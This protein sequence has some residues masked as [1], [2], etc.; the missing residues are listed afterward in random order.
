LLGPDP[1]VE[2]MTRE[3]IDD[4]LILIRMIYHD[5][6]SVEDP[7]FVKDEILYKR[8][9]SDKARE[10]LSDSEL[11]RLINSGDIAELNSRVLK[12]GA[13]NLLWNNVPLQGDLAL[14]HADV[15][16]L[17]VFSQF[18]TLLYGEGSSAE[19]LQ[20]WADFLDSRSLN[21][22]WTTP[23]YFMFLTAP[24]S[25][26][27]IKPGAASW[28]LKQAGLDTALGAK[29]SG[30]IYGELRQIATQI[31]DLT[32]DL[33]VRDVID[34]QSMV[35]TAFQASQALRKRLTEIQAADSSIFD[36]R[37]KKAGFPEL[38]A[39][40]IRRVLSQIPLTNE[41][42]TS[43]IH[44]FK[45]GA[46]T[47]DNIRRNLEICGV[48][49]F[50]DEMMT[51]PGEGGYTA[52]GRFLINGL[53]ADQL[54]T[55]RQ[56]LLDIAN[57][58]SYKEVEQIVSAFEYKDVPLVK[59]GI[60]SPWIHYLQPGICPL[61]NGAVLE[62]YR[63]LGLPKQGTYTDALRIARVAARQIG[64]T[65]LGMLDALLYAESKIRLSAE[66]AISY[67]KIA[68]GEKA[69]QWDE[70]K[71]NGFIAVGWDEIGNVIGLDED[72]F[73]ARRKEVIAHDP[74]L[75]GQKS[76][77]KAHLRHL[78]EF[79]HLKPGD[80]VI[81]NQGIRLILGVGTVTG[82]PFFVEGVRHCHRIPVKWDDVSQKEINEPSWVRTMIRLTPQKFYQLTASAH[83]EQDYR[84]PPVSDQNAA[85]TLRAFELLDGICESPTKQYYLDHRDDF[86]QYI[87]QPF[88]ATFRAAVQ[89][90]PEQIKSFMET[91]DN[92]FSRFPKNDYG[93]GRAY[94]W[95]WGAIYPRGSQRIRGIQLYTTISKDGMRIGFD[96][97]MDTE[98]VQRLASAI[99]S[100][101]MQVFEEVSES[102]GNGQWK[103]GKNTT[104]KNPRSDEYPWTTEAL[105][106]W[107]DGM[108]DS[109]ARVLMAISK[110]ELLNLLSEDLSESISQAFIALFPL[111][112][113]S[114]GLGLSSLS[115][116]TGQ[117]E[118]ENDLKVQE[119]YS[120]YL[121]EQET[122]FAQEEFEQWAKALLRK[123]QAIFY[124]P[125]GTGKTFIA[126]KLADHIVGGTTGKIDLIQFHPSYSYE[127]FMQGLRP[128]TKDGQLSFRMIPGRFL[129]FCEEAE[130]RNGAPCVLIIDEINRA[131]LSKVLGELMYLLEYRNESIPLASGKR[132]SIPPNVLI[133]G[134]MNTADRS[135]AL[136]D[137]ALR[138]RFAFIRLEPNLPLL[139]RKLA[140]DSPDFPADRLIKIIKLINGEIKEEGFHLGV[141][142]FLEKDLHG[143]IQLIWQSEIEPYLEE[144]FFDE[145]GKM[146]SFRWAEVRKEL[147]G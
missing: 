147:F 112:Q 66:S 20:K 27:F 19:R 31:L 85:F 72:S 105:T 29:P 141:T 37:A 59:P 129:E 128:E 77:T 138:R 88:K 101:R 132:F 136:V 68:P 33:G 117:I 56:F 41:K 58:G 125:P 127:D 4:L 144:Y 87:E 13:T 78:W 82:E 14:F 39:R 71:K 17:D 60:Y 115:S 99:E 75:A 54:E 21:N 79:V 7:A 63:D 36:E 3:Q 110:A 61:L 76:W 50:Y 80:K 11:Q 97:S 98:A 92:L 69:W 6:S 96:A 137:F 93:R 126:R 45:H 146:R 103:Y 124:G 122:G 18:R 35:W 100:N 94:P 133:I 116:L 23:T 47:E 32:G 46:A 30:K 25:D 102:L 81:A 107:L 26:I 67:W 9:A 16:D 118:F 109:G 114:S 84:D 89:R 131:N 55:V 70:C 2:G 1:K 28:L 140:A 65:D 44:L 52:V 51:H 74:S 91:E 5:F 130:Q 104:G 143:R 42:L 83:A 10:L 34:V 22:K 8:K 123:R 119:E 12:V 62:R 90:L 43:F 40:V 53:T 108:P 139:Q 48:P 111:V 86:I 145:P 24:S 142:F 135:I 15:V 106:T 121:A 113:L 120:A 57:A 38:A 49:E 73:E 64:I 95:F 134:T